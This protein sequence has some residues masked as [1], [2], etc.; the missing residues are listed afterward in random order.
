MGILPFLGLVE[1]DLIAYA[2]G[3]YLY[4]GC[5]FYVLKVSRSIK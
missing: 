5:P 4:S 3:Q 2:K 1:I